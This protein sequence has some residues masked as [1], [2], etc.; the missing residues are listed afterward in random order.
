[1]VK[2][3]SWV[4]GR[5][6]IW[7]TLEDSGLSDREKLFFVGWLQ[8]RLDGEAIEVSSKTERRYRE[9]LRLIGQ[10]APAEI[11]LRLNYET[12]YEEVA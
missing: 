9:V 6:S 12:G 11:R 4:G 3:G 10:W 2:F 5:Q 1:L 8:A 7:R